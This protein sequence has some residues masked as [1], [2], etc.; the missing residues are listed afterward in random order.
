[1][2][3]SPTRSIEAIL[4]RAAGARARLKWQGAVGHGTGDQEE[5]TRSVCCQDTAEAYRAHGVVVSHPLRM[6]KALG[7]IPS[8]SICQH[9]ANARPRQGRVPEQ[10]LTSHEMRSGDCQDSLPEWSK[11]VDSSSTSESCVGSNPTAVTF[12]LGQVNQPG[13]GLKGGD[14]AAWHRRGKAPT[15]GL[16][17][18][19]TRLRALRSAD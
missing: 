10:G 12:T 18:T 19:T 7:S 14:E 11:G 4:T 9:T 13:K 3:S 15:V 17:P 2:G 6:R 16:E 1:V 8:V 5:A